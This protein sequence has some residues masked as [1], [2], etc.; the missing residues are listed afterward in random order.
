V[1]ELVKLVMQKTGLA[2]GTAMITVSLVINYLRDKL[3]DQA[4]DQIDELLGGD[5]TVEIMNHYL[6]RA[7]KGLGEV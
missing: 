1:E 5:R 6:K 2:Q 3:P 4:V 7:G